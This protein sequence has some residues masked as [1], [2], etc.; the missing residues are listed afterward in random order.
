MR[1]G[2]ALRL[3][4]RDLYEN[5]WRLAPINAAIGLVLVAAGFAAVGARAALLLVVAAGPVAAGLVHSAVVLVHTG[6]VTLGDAVEGVRLHWRRGLAL[7]AGGTALLFLGVLAIRFYLRFQ[8]GLPLAFLT[9]Y[10]LVMLGIYQ[11]VLW[12]LAIAEP[13]RRLRQLAVDAAA[14]GAARPGA[15][16]LLGLA[17]LLVNLVGIA[18][19]LLPFLTLTV[20]YSFVAVAHF[21][22]EEPS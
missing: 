17:L 12:T 1:P 22:L 3:A 13:E 15:T 6:N 7:G 10:V 9:I 5:S 21:T 20:A 16:L 14:F 11:G 4:T 2:K 18:A 19:A 8:F